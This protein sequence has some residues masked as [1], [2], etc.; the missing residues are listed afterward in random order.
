M[1]EVCWHKLRPPIRPG[2]S[3]R[4]SLS[5]TFSRTEGRFA[6]VASDSIGTK[7]IR[8]TNPGLENAGEPALNDQGDLT[9]RWQG[10]KRRVLNDCLY[11]T[12]QGWNFLP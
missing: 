11:G 3:L 4:I 8:K 6:Y 2:L 12:T 7:G 1:P 10:I 9:K 5:Y